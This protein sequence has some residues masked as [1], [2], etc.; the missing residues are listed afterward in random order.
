MEKQKSLKLN[1]IMNALLTMSSIIFPFLTFPYISRILLP[2]GTG[3]VSFATSLI[4]Y[5]EVFAKLGIPTYGIRACAKVRDDKEE[6]SRT[7]H[8]LL[9]INMVTCL[10]TYIALGFALVY[11]P[12]LREERTLYII[13]SA[14]IFLNAIGM[15]W[16]YKALEKYSYIT[17][18][19]LV[20]KVIALAMMYL[21]VHQQKDYV[22]YG[23]ISIFASSASNILN[24]IHARRYISTRPVGNYHPKRHL[25]AVA[26]FFAMACATTIYTHLDTVMLGFMCDDEEVGYYSA[27]VKI[28]AI[29][30]SLVTSLGVVLLPRVSYYVEHGMMEEFK[31]VSKKALNFVFLCASPLMIYFILFAKDGILLLSGE[32]YLNSVLPM[33]IIMPTLLLIGIT[34]ILGIQILLPLGKEKTVLY[35]EIAGA[36]VDLI[37]NALLIPRIASAGAAIGTVAAE[38]VVLVVQYFALKEESRRLFREIPYRPLLAALAAGTL[39]C[40][41]VLFMPWNCF[42]RLVASAVCFFGVYGIVLLMMKEELT[43]EI[44]NQVLEKLHIAGR[45]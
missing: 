44:V 38:F 7:V 40:A 36:V 18:R 16:L 19:S 6:L 22:I 21:L 1:F 27:A 4:S 8:E 14:T 45:I 17:I 41:W 39:A 28:K 31:R 29:L 12:R 35:S 23:F 33:Q 34:N 25:K 37:L 30:V 42:F 10:I 13:I 3:K 32:A 24:F 5:F 15:E 11:V 9:A 2:L 20:F 26:I 43:R